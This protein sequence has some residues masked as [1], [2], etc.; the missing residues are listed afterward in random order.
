MNWDILENFFHRVK[1]RVDPYKRADF[2]VAISKMEKYMY[3]S[4]PPG[5]LCCVGRWGSQIF[6]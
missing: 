6:V 2:Q 5:A 3:S 4:S 1:N